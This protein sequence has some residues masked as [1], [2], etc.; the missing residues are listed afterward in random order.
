MEEIIKII[1][2]DDHPLF[3]KG[4]FDIISEEKSIEIIGEACDGEDAFKLI[5]NLAPDIA[6]LDIDM[7][8]KNGLQIL[9]DP[10]LDKI[11]TKIVFLTYYKEED[12]FNEAIEHGVTGY[13]LK[14]NAITDILDCIK[15]VIQNRYYISPVMSGYLLNRN[16]R[17]KEFKTANPLLKKLTQTELRILKLV[18]NEKSSKEIAKELY[19]SYRTVENHRTIINQKLNLHGSHSLSKF[20]LENKSFL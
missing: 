4:L 9:R 2:A 16:E 8:K 11:K 5:K 20:A 15:S 3:R 14:E 7:P 17:I 19:I 10:T 18:A 6:I 12:I 13:V 1:I